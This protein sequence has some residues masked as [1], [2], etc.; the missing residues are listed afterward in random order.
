MIAEV[1]AIVAR[2]MGVRRA[3][4]WLLRPAAFGV[5]EGVIGLAGPPDAGKTTL[6]A[7]FATLRRPHVGALEVLG[8]DA[9]DPADLREIRARVGYL[10]SG[11]LDWAASMRVREF[12]SYAAFYKRMEKSATVSILARMELTEVAEWELGRL[13]ADIR[14]RAGIAAACVHGP[15]LLLL[16][17]PLRDLDDRQ[18]MELSTVMPS[19][20]RTVLL[21]AESPADLTGWCHRVFSLA[22]G[23]LTELA[24]RRPYPV[25]SPPGGRSLSPVAR[26][27]HPRRA[28]DRTVSPFSKAPPHGEG[29]PHAESRPYGQPSPYGEAA[30]LGEAPSFDKVSP[31]AEAP[32]FGEARPPREAPP[33]RQAPPRG[34]WIMGA[35][36]G[37]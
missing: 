37:V 5:A 14:L 18:A 35:C 15:E 7:T 24:Y 13:P 27:P 34:G 1:S 20:A 30:S 10:P 19:L 6:L 23:R 28:R 29:P 22:R 8:Y 26:R 33:R 17:E 25:L 4:R 16:D 2:G 3:G 32:S 36:A 11:G 9:G 31:F 21:T 12:V